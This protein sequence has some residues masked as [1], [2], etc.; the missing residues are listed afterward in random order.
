MKVVGR[1]ILVEFWLRHPRARG[2]LS[3][4]YEMVQS[5]EWRSPMDVRE[6]FNALEF[7]EDNRVVMGVGGDS[8]RIVV[9]ISY[10]LQQVMVRFVGA[11]SEFED[12]DPG[13]V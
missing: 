12:I 6:G 13:T 2:P 9:L 3:A 5:A 8:F 7:V 1:R 10:P 11:R 4:W